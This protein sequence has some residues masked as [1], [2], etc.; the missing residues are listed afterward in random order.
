MIEIVYFTTKN[1]ANQEKTFETYKAFE[2]WI[3]KNESI[4]MD[5]TITK[6]PK[7]LHLPPHYRGHK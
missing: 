3:K 4:L 6:A 7:G 2:S 1:S 5:F